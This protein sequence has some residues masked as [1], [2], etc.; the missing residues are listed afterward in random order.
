[1]QE[2][3]PCTIY[4]HP[5]AFSLLVF[6]LQI[7]MMAVLSILLTAP[8][9][10]AGIALT[11]PLLMRRVQPEQ[12]DMQTGD[13]LLCTQDEPDNETIALNSMT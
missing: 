7:V 12:E 6:F 11:G 3:D 8:V 2:P 13:Q 10:A 9:G 4:C 5:V 1:M